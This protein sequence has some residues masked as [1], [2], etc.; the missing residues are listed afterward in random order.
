MYVLCNK[1]AIYPADLMVLGI[2]EAKEKLARQG[3]SVVDDNLM[4]DKRGIEYKSENAEPGRKCQYPD[5]RLIDIQS[6][7]ELELLTYEDLKIPL[8]C[9]AQV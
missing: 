7:K 2:Q 3:G 5:L 6:S 4:I 8:R 1:K 9:R